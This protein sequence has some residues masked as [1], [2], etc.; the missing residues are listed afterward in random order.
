V[1]PLDL[2]ANAES[3]GARV[4]RAATIADLHAALSPGAGGDGFPGP[5]VVYIETDRYAGVPGYDSWWD[6]PVAEVSEQPTVRAARE[7]YERDA[8]AQ[9][10][11]V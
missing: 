10:Q 7:Q 11:F 6:V 8:S 9:R 5:T 1:L 2:A 3:L 4:I